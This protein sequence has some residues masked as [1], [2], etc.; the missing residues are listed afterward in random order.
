MPMYILPNVNALLSFSVLKNLAVRL[1]MLS[2]GCSGSKDGI[3]LGRS[4]DKYEGNDLSSTC[5]RL[6]S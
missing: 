3:K 6:R 5:L 4:S 2:N 1:Y